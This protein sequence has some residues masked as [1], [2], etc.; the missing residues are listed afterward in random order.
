MTGRIKHFLLHRK[1][2]KTC[3]VMCFRRGSD[4]VISRPPRGQGVYT[5]PIP[6]RNGPRSTPGFPRSPQLPPSARGRGRKPPPPVP[7]GALGGFRGLKVPFSPGKWAA[8]WEL[9]ATCGFR[10][11]N[12]SSWVV[13]TVRRLGG[14]GRCK[15]RCEGK[16]V[17]GARKWGRLR[18]SWKH[19]RG[20]YCH[21]I[22]TRTPAPRPLPQAPRSRLGGALSGGCPA[23]TCLGGAHP[24]AG[25]GRLGLWA[26]AHK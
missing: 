14:Q 16:K 6:T 12:C 25:K 23:P 13:G 21:T 1:E 24:P 5:S 11:P 8:T 18:P 20:L 9:G 19:R 2:A 3:R 17:R 22:R 4:P 10:A 26:S 15:G 7:A